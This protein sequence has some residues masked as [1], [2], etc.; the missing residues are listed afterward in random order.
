MTNLVGFWN[1]VWNEENEYQVEHVIEQIFFAVIN[2][3]SVTF[4]LPI[5]ILMN[6][7][8]RKPVSALSVA[9][10]IL[11]GAMTALAVEIFYI[12]G[13][14]IPALVS[15]ATHPSCLNIFTSEV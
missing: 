12:S 11:G 10:R 8:R 7:K 14:M 1:N 9:A 6:V 2:L 4:F 15:I 13:T 5:Q 3:S